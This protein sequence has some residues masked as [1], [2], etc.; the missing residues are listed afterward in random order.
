MCAILV[1]YKPTVRPLDD[2]LNLQEVKIAR[3]CPNQ[4][5]Q[6]SGSVLLMRPGHHGGGVSGP[7][8]PFVGI[9]PKSDYTPRINM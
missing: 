8:G 2:A 3:G 5:Q 4:I 6:E 9:S 7:C 1:V